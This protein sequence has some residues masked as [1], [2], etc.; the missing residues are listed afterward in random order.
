VEAVVS[1]NLRVQED[2]AEGRLAW[3][4]EQ[5]RLREQTP[6][7]ALEELHPMLAVTEPEGLVLLS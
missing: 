7:A 3:H 4:L 2:L 5:A 6:E 1:F